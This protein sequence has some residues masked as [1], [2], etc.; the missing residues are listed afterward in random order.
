MIQQLI[1]MS[2]DEVLVKLAEITVNTKELSHV[3]NQ[4]I[5]TEEDINNNQKKTVDDAAAIGGDTTERFSENTTS[6]SA[7]SLED[8]QK[9]FGGNIVNKYLME[10]RQM[11][12]K[13]Y[14]SYTKGLAQ[15]EL[16]DHP[17]L[18]TMFRSEDQAQVNFFEWINRF[19]K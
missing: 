9:I 13:E 2:K 5:D 10:T 18:Y 19:K 7:S 14:L 4:R 3:Q 12:R 6:E 8:L 15:S 1:F 17:L 11:T 16:M